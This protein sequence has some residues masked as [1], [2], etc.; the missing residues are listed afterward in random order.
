MTRILTLFACLGLAACGSPAKNDAANAADAMTSPDAVTA[1][2]I[3]DTQAAEVEAM[4]AADAE[5]DN[6]DE[7]IDDRTSEAGGNASK[8]ADKVS[9]TTKVTVY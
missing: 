2:A 8:T 7:T 3:T 4:K 1:E 5:L 6:L 9:R